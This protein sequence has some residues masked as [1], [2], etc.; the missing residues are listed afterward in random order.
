MH[1][2]RILAGKGQGKLARPLRQALDGYFDRRRELMSLD[3]SELQGIGRGLRLSSKVIRGGVLPLVEA[4]LEA[5]Q[6]SDG[7]RR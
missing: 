2:A 5:E 6:S 4:I 3:R 7:E 1:L